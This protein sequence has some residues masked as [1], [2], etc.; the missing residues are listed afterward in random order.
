MF[1]KASLASLE[2]FKE[3]TASFR[4]AGGLYTVPY[5]DGLGYGVRENMIIIFIYTIN[6]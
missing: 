4:V 2:N 6:Y 1:P 5:N 3:K